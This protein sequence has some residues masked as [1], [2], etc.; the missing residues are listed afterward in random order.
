MTR[1]ARFASV[2]GAQ[3][4]LSLGSGSTLSV[5]AVASYRCLCFAAG[6]KIVAVDVSDQ[7]DD[8]AAS[9]WGAALLD[10]DTR[11]AAVEVWQLARRVCRH[12][13]QP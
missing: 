11:C 3:G 2:L 6:G 8:E 5:D 7:P 13:P 12:E 9:R 1:R 10:R 4:G